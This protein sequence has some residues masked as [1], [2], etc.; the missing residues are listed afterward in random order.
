MVSGLAAVALPTALT[1]QAAAVTLTP[2]R[3]CA[4]PII[5]P[6]TANYAYPDTNAAY[7]VTAAILG[8]DDRITINGIDPKA[9]YWSMQTYRFSDSTLLD[10]VNDATVRRTGKN[11][12][13]AIQVVHPSKANPRNPNILTGAGAF[14]GVTFG[15]NLTV[16]MMRVYVSGTKSA[17]GGALPTVTL[18]SGT[19]R[20]A[21][22]R[23][24]KTCRGDQITPPDNRPA[25][26]PAEGA[27]DRFV[28]AG[29]ERFYP[30]ADAV[31]LGAQQSYDPDSILVV[32][33]K[34]PR[35]PRDVR[36][37]SLCQNV[38]EGDLPVVDCLRDSQVDLDSRGFFRIAVVA[39]EQ[40]PRREWAAYPDVDF[41][42]WSAATTGPLPDAFLI[43][44]N[45]LPRK[46]F[47][48]SVARVP[49]NAFADEHIGAHAPII[50][51]MSRAEFDAAYR[52]GA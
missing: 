30:S 23:T 47:V 21:T 38:N 52:T 28:R 4:W 43:F 1:P 18:R 20:D 17:S 34:A 6:G 50:T 16:I 24:L 37:W 42:R 41:L 46:G 31:Y 7:F 35:V 14:D 39:A 9:R 33:A 13:W 29:A 19:G 10:A 45:L 8:K 15:S 48:G 40:I 5:Y 44:R 32:S 25:L 26:E 49:V 36:Y 2:D 11:K 12:Q 22:V 3:G 27:T 51:M